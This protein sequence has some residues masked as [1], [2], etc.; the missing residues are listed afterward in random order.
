MEHVTQLNTRNAIELGNGQKDT[1]RDKQIAPNEWSKYF[2][3]TLY[4]F[5]DRRCEL[6]QQLIDG[7]LASKCERLFEQV[8]S[9][10]L[11][12]SRFLSF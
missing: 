3:K 11:S 8:R 7:L 1:Q 9:L 12:L 2:P 5:Q 10:S 6:S 4:R